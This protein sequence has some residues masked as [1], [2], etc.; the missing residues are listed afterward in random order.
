MW[1][2]I[3][4]LILQGYFNQVYTQLVMVICR[5]DSYT[6]MI[7]FQMYTT[8]VIAFVFP[9]TITVLLIWKKKVLLEQNNIA[10]YGSLYKN[11]RVYE[12]SPTGNIFWLTLFLAKRL[13]I[14]LI[15]VLIGSFTWAQIAL[16]QYLQLFVLMHF[17]YYFPMESATQNWMETLNELFVLFCS[18]FLLLFTDLIPSIDHRY[19]LGDLF[20]YILL[21]L[22]AV[23][24]IIITYWII[25]HIIR[26]YQLRQK[27]KVLHH[28]YQ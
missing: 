24:V 28:F 21:T 2:S 6:F 3:L 19:M 5:N 27:R 23:D 13:S 11:V 10:K 4:R 16:F 20:M 1:S 15:T 9:T 8:L 7:D 26:M 12:H 18:Y 25:K 22:A 14:A 17:M